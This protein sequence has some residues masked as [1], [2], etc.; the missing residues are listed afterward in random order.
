MM[1]IGPS[2]AADLDMWTYQALLWNWNKAHNPEPQAKS[3]DAAGAERLDRAL[4]AHA[5]N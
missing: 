2:E 4:R 5:I 1:G 3:L